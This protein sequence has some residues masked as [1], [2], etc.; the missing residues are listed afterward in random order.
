[1][2]IWWLW[3]KHFQN[4]AT[5]SAT[6]ARHEWDVNPCLWSQPSPHWNDSG[7]GLPLET[8]GVILRGLWLNHKRESLEA[9]NWHKA[10][11]LETTLFIEQNHFS[12]FKIIESLFFFFMLTMKINLLYIYIDFLWVYW[13]SVI[14]D[15]WKSEVLFLYSFLL[16]NKYLWCS[17]HWDAGKFGLQ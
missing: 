16:L 4:W 17:K 11:K 3:G 1:M 7:V 5:M 13:I 10:M 6:K 12:C 9:E 14:C 8:T 2:Q 15:V